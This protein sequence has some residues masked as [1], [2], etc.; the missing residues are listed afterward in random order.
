[1]R[2]IPETLKNEDLSLSEE[3]KEVLKLALVAD[4]GQYSL[5]N[6]WVMCSYAIQDAI[7]RKCGNEGISTK[8][9]RFTR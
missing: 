8:N 7:Y 9:I 4:G 1:V 2:L 6:T 5:T 3:W